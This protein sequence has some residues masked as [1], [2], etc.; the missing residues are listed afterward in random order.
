MAGQEKCQQ[1]HKTKQLT[2]QIEHGHQDLFYLQSTDLYNKQQL[3]Q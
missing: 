2:K 1:K 3:L